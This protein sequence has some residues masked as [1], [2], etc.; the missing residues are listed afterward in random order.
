MRCA[1][2][3]R[4]SSDLQRESSIED[5]ERRCRHYAERQGWEV[6]EEFVRADKAVS[7]A[8]LA[9][10]GQLDALVQAVKW[11]PR[12]FD[13][14]LVDDT[15]RLARDYADSSKL[16]KTLQY[17]SVEVTVV[18]NGID[19][20]QKSSKMMM[21]FHGIIDEQY[22]DGLAE[23]VHRG[24]EGRV[25][26]G[27]NPGGRIYGYRN[28]PIEDPTR[29]GKYG[30]PA[31]LGVQLEVFEE[32]ATV[33]RRIFDLYAA[34]MGFGAIA[35]LLNSEG[36]RPPQPPRNRED[37][38]WCPT[39]IRAMLRNERYRGVFE[40]N[41]TKKVRNPE[42]GKKTSRKRETDDLVRQEIP[43]W[44]LVT[45]E[46]WEAARQQNERVNASGI[47]R[48]GGQY[49]TENSKSYV[50]SGILRCSTCGAKMVIVSGGGKRGY[51]KYGC[52]RHRCRGTCEN[53]LYIRR[54]RLEEQLFAALEQRLFQPEMLDAVITRVRD[55]VARRVAEMEQQGAVTTV[56][57]LK[58]RRD[59][60]QA[61]VDR[62]TNAIATTDGME[63][64]VAKL[65]AVV[66]ELQAVEAQIATYRPM[67]LKITDQQVRQH[68][69]KTLLVLKTK[70]V[71]DNVLVARAALQKHIPQLVLTPV[72]REGKPVYR[73]S[74]EMDISGGDKCVMQVVARDGLEPPTP[75]FSGPRST[76]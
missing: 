1:I 11:K 4:Y 18:A 75:A 8:S 2:Y 13:R 58:R 50:F 24:Q 15:S 52:P 61:Q 36:V 29:T 40:W 74:G 45:E 37:K 5:Q 73:V 26:N 55:G 67:D 27:F 71:D 34:G 60:L 49:R 10:R 3:T 41:R 69:T 14:L 39:A 44:R 72:E 56:D 16:V 33:I 59:D 19:T 46:Q 42:T 17:Y 63:V 32:Q 48:L 9:G 38:G 31:V 65:K 54:D 30:R 35:K 70:L 43:G 25:L 22:L 21:A 12:P 7:G 64:L 28:V 68:V 62:L 23:K 47:Q 76:N 53:K 51:V 66:A 57:T 6:V 20:S